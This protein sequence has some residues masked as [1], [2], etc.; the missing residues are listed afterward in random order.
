VSDNKSPTD[1]INPLSSH[2]NSNISAQKKK[3]ISNYFDENFL[4]V[5]DVIE[6]GSI[7]I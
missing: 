4:K 1:H 3:K 2:A 7:I 6:I 5:L